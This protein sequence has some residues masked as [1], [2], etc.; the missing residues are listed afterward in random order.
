MAKFT[1]N[2]D[3]PTSKERLEAIK[4]ID[5]ASLTKTE[6]ETVSNY[7]LY[8][9]DE[10]GKSVVDRKEVQI[11]TKFSSYQKD[12]F[13]SLDE[14]MESPTFDEGILQKNRTIYK[15]IKPSIDKEKTKDVPGMLELWES[16]DRMD[17]ELKAL[18]EK[19][20]QTAED[21][22]QIYYMNHHLIALR[23]QQY[24]LMDSVFPTTLTQKNKAE[25]HPHP[26]EDQMNYPILPR[27]VMLEKNDKWFMFPRLAKNF[28]AAAP[29]IYTDQEVQEMREK[30]KPFFDFR[31]A[32][33]L[34][35]LIQHY[36]EIEAFVEEMPDSPLHNLLWTLDF[37]IDKA[38]L[39]E[40][41]ML[42]VRDKKSRCPNKEIAKHLMD[43]LGI[44][45]QENYISTIWNKCCQ[46][47][48][49]AVEL[50]YDEY[51]CRNYDK[52]W[53]VC[54]RCKTELLRDPRNFVK[55]AKASDGLTG[56]C[57]VCDKELRQMN[58]K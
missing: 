9:K 15:K 1:L 58:K 42:I 27:G 2:F 32:D 38:K 43:E 5:L 12:K 50:N 37:Y 33:H 54:S 34:Y 16:I 4:K 28:G 47:I 49:D 3:I 53:K 8:G 56:R 45:H 21:R 19:P 44:Y 23:K 40:Q 52:A 6:L 48:A 18:K 35:Q 31:N 51:L 13:V 57:K 39:S 14:M 11:K 36:A 7:V 41:Q 55:K 29:K 30:G 17:A 26:T 25:Y 24:Y 22:K 10:D 20:D 46:L